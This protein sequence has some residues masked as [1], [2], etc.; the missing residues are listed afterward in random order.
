MEDNVVSA[1]C[2]FLHQLYNFLGKYSDILLLS[3]IQIRNII[4]Q[5]KISTSQ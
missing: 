3:K 1:S 2:F 4:N 5:R